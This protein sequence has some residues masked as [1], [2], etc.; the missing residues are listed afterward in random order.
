MTKLQEH[1]RQLNACSEARD[2]AAAKT[3][4]ETAAADK[5]NAELCNEIRKILVLPWSE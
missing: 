1:L 5:F 2:F 3:A 4:Q